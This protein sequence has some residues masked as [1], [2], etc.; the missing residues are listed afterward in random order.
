MPESMTAGLQVLYVTGI[1]VVGYFVMKQLVLKNDWVIIAITI[2][3]G[4]G[5]PI[6]L[7]VIGFRWSYRKFIEKRL[8]QWL[9]F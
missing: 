4:L 6:T 5:W 7:V 2:V 8:K 1:F 3:S 9:K